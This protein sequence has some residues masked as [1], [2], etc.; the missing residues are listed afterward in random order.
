MTEHEMNFDGAQSLPA[1]RATAEEIVAN[2]NKALSLYAEAHAAIVAADA[3][4]T[5]ARTQARLA[6]PTENRFNINNREAF[7]TLMENV[8]VPDR[9]KFLDAARRVTDTDIW[10]HLVQSTAMERLMDKKAKDDFARQLLE[11]VPE[12]TVDNLLATMEGLF[13]D[14]GMIFKRGIANAFCKLDRRFKSHDGWKIGSRVILTRVFDER[15]HWNFYGNERDTMQDIERT[16][17]VIDG[18]NPAEAY[19][20]LVGAIEV[21]RGRDLFR[22][23]RQTEVDSD[24]FKVRIFKNGNAHIWFKRD[25]LVD[26]VNQLLGEYYGAPIPE[27]READEDTGLYNAKTTPAKSFGFFPTPPAVVEQVISAAKV[28]P[29]ADEPRM[30]ILEPSAGTGNLASAC[31][32]TMER[33]KDWSG[34]GNR[35]C[36]ERWRKTYRWDNEVDCIEMQPHLAAGLAAS[37]KYRR[38][39][40]ADF[41]RVPP[42]PEYD[43][44]VMNPPFDRER[45]IDHVLHALQFLKEDGIL[46]AVMSAGTEFRETKKSIAFRALM[47]SM[48]AGFQDLPAGSFSSVGTNVNTILL[49]V[50][51]DRHSAHQHG[52]RFE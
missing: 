15:G 51:A 38:V 50:Y 41:L 28:F 2:R 1:R 42:A 25:D 18:R 20:S 44:V 23:A 36:M 8:R 39:I 16:F 17:L 13:A 6:A 26:K 35:E 24:F 45:D 47:K 31:L 10:A 34:Y 27:E 7:A 40:N 11:N 9:Q 29:G 46:V 32:P 5:G 52:R 3:A 48:G 33:F 43:R 19:G 37:G 14:A 22:G 49:T 30:R 4:I 12:V 21:A